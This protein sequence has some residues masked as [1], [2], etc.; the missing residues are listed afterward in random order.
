M[1][2][3]TSQIQLR[4]LTL[5]TVW[6]PDKRAGCSAGTRSIATHGVLNSRISFTLQVHNADVT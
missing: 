5:F 4:C 1:M 2:L 6:L 3:V